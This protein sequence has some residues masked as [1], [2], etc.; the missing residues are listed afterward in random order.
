MEVIIKEIKKYVAHDGKEFDTKE[1]CIIYETD[2]LNKI[3]YYRICFNFD[4]CEGRGWLNCAY[5]AVVPVRDVS[6][7]DIAFE[8]A[9]RMYGEG[10]Y[11]TPG[12]QG[13]GAVPT[14]KVVEVD[15]R[16]YSKHEQVMSSAFERE[17]PEQIL[18]SPFCLKGFKKV[19]D[20]TEEWN[21]RY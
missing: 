19:Y 3:K 7:Y 13:F 8:Y 21:I 5:A 1:E 4:L 2:I 11:I 20:Y 12:I 16:I 14:F 17:K 10:H 18:L 6:P 9:L 15:E